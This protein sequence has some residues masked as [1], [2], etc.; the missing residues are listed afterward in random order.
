MRTLALD[1]SWR[2]SLLVIAVKVVCVLAICHRSS[3]AASIADAMPNATEAQREMIVAQ[4]CDASSP[5]PLP[6]EQPH[7]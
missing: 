5:N 4:C 7:L 2:A 3:S 6:A 1:K